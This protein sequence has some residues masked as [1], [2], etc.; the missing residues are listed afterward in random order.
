MFKKEEEKLTDYK[1]VYDN[2]EIPLQLVDEAIFAGFHRAKQEEVRKPRRKKWLFSGLAAAIILIGFFTSIRLSPAFADYITVIPGMEKIVDLIRNDK[3]K[4]L[5]I[6]NDYYQKIGVSQE[7]HGLKV[8]ID[9]AI[10]DENGLVLFYSLHS[11]NNQE[12]LTIEKAELKNRDGEKLPPGSSDY[13]ALHSSEKGQTNYS[14]T[15]EYFFESPLK[16]KDFKFNLQVKGEG[17]NESYTLPFSLKKEVQAKKTYTINKTVTIEG[18]KITVLDATVYPLR[19]AIYVK[20]DPAN[21]KKLLDFED[22][23][24]ID[25]NGETWNK[26]TNGI[27]ANNISDDEKI[28]YLQSNYFREPKELY[29]VLNKVQAIDKE[30]AYVVVDPEKQQI[31]KQPK[32]NYLSSFKVE[33]NDLIFKLRTN[34]NYHSFPFLRIKVG[35]GKEIDSLSMSLSGGEDN[36]EQVLGVTIPHLKQQ[37]GPISLEI[38]SFPTWIKGDV[39]VKIK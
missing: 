26:I 36:E 37:K 32:G 38:S 16:T 11:S 27:T 2:V 8:T 14:G 9:G 17:V 35:N 33:G 1:N 29:L 15:Y 12:E 21:T 6:E 20:M 4:L 13:D 22:L 5:A 3:G 18:Q 30:D 23:R 24:L 34:G 28:I 7:K 25:E 19:V 31:L 10:E 39:K